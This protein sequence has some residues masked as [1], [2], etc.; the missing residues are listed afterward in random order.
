MTARD[1]EAAIQSHAERLAADIKAGLRSAD[2][3]W[4]GYTARNQSSDEQLNLAFNPPDQE[5]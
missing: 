3:K 4:I 5:A 2:G 1:S